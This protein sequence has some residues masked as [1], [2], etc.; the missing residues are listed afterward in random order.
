M[1][2]IPRSDD[3]I[4]IHTNYHISQS[5]KDFDPI[6]KEFNIHILRDMENKAYQITLNCYDIQTLQRYL[7]RIYPKESREIKLK[8]II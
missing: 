3:G 7:H 1:N 2:V 8:R 5:T 6:E 4:E